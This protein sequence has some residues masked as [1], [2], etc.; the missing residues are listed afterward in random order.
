[1]HRVHL[2]R[3]PGRCTYEASFTLEGRRIFKALG[4]D[5]RRLDEDLVAELEFKLRR[6]ELHLLRPIPAE[7]ALEAYLAYQRGRR[8][9]KGLK[10]DEGYLR[11][12]LGAMKVEDLQDLT[13]EIVRSF[14]A[15]RR[16]AGRSATTV[17]RNREVLHT[18]GSWAVNQGYLGGSEHPF[19]ESVETKVD[20][21]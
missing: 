16:A 17:N 6:R 7:T 1:M 21:E 19:R 18:L 2:R 9:A 13:T 12:A 14:L 20:G 11:R 8:A 4:T 10:T 3:R 15:D 5:D